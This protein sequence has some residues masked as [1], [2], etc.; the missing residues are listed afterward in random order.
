MSP[1]FEVIERCRKAAGPDRDIDVAIVM[2]L[3]PD[4]GPY[5]PHCAGDEP[6]FWNDPYRKQRC[7]KFTESLDA[8]VTL[9]PRGCKWSAGFSRHVPHSV[10]VWHPRETGYYEGECDGGR[11]IAICIAALQAHDGL[12]H[13]S[14]VRGDGQ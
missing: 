8:A 7:P 9:I 2:A 6:I 5:Q 4:I 13:L 11:A 3:Y 10:Q 1:I 14:Q 12:S